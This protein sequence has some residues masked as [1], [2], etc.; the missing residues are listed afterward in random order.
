M[1]ESAS[2][3]H[4]SNTVVPTAV[5]KGD[6]SPE[7]IV[8][9][10]FHNLLSRRPSHSEKTNCLRSCADVRGLSR[11]VQRICASPEYKLKTFQD[12]PHPPGHYYSPINNTKALDAKAMAERQRTISIDEIR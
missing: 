4:N 2:S 1:S 7:D 10:L 11:E 5:F 12:I 9:Q 6:P 3:Q 8:D